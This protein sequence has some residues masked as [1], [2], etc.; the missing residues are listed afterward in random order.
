MN[1]P[2]LHTA[3][4]SSERQIRPN[5]DWF[6]ILAISFVLLA[7]SIGWNVLVFVRVTR[8]EALSG[9]EHASVSQTAASIT[10]IHEAFEQRAR[11]S[12]RYKTEYQFVDPSRSGG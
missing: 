1:I 4:N 8:G 2:F 6:I 12:A 3:T 11:E 7:I 10:E 5:R 9:A